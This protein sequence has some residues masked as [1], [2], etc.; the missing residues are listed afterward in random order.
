MTFRRAGVDAV[1]LDGRGPRPRHRPDRD[2]PPPTIGGIDR[3]RSSGRGPRP[4]PGARF[5]SGSLIAVRASDGVAPAWR[6][7]SARSGRPPT[8]GGGRGRAIRRT[9]PAALLVT[10]LTVLVVAMARPQSVI[11][12]P[13]FEGTVVLAFDVSGSM[14]ATDIQPTR[15]EA[16]KAAARAFVSRQPG[17]DPDRRGRV[18]RRGFSVTVPTDDQSAVL[19]AIDRWARARDVGRRRD[20]VLDDGDRDGR[21]GTPNWVLHEQSRTRDLTR[22]SCPPGASP[23]R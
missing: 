6:R 9:I 7:P 14:A 5:R 12:V 2:A 1:S 13:R 11:G 8:P 21:D 18:Q 23:R 17:V 10:G 22:R 19:A 15:M 3:C 20:P 4:A 16:A